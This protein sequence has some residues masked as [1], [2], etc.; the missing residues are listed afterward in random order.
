MIAF[1][2]RWAILAVAV[3]VAAEMVD[4]IELE[5]WEST[6]IVALILGLLNVII[7]PI[8]FFLSLPITIVTFGLFLIVLNA[9]MLWLTDWIAGQF[10]DLHFQ[11]VDFWWDA[12]LGAIIISIVSWA[13]QLFIKPEKVARNLR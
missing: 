7:K 12:I 5:G 2:V 10:D 9:I 11:V 4:G 8:L 3:W 13:I 1:L 6:V